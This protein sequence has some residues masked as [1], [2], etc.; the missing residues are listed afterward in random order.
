[1]SFSGLNTK[2]NGISLECSDL[3]VNDSINENDFLLFG[4]KTLVLNSVLAYIHRKHG[5]INSKLL[6]SKISEFYDYENL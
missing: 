3:N 5:P 2:N 4:N 6:C 1:M